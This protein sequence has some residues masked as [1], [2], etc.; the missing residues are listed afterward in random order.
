MRI[1]YFF[2]LIH[3]QDYVDNKMFLLYENVLPDGA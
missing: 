3:W 2:Y 1:F